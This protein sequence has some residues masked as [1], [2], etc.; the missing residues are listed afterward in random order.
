MDYFARVL[1][2]GF[3]GYVP[4][5][6]GCS[7]GCCFAA[8]FWVAAAV[9]SP[10]VHCSMGFANCLCVV[11]GPVLLCCSGSTV[12][13]IAILSLTLAEVACTGSDALEAEVDVVLAAMAVASCS[14]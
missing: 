6:V 2:P 9:C 3:V 12:V 10:W 8:A 13:V 4:W 1:V 14:G 7:T 5:A 11:P